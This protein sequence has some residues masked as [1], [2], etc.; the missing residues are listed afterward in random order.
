MFPLYL[1]YHKLSG[2]RLWFESRGEKSIL[3]C[4]RIVSGVW[5]CVVISRNGKGKAFDGSDDG[6]IPSASTMAQINITLNSTATQSAITELT[7]KLGNLKPVMASIGEYML[8]EVRGRFDSETAP[9]GTKWASLAAATIADKARRQKSGTTRSGGSRARVNASPNAILKSTFL[10]RDTIAYKPSAFE[11]RIG[12]PQK[13]G[14]HH[15]YG[16]SRMAARPFLGYNQA[17]IKE[18]EAIVVDALEIL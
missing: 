6:S 8:R 18:I 5:E 15:Q 4:D 1:H 12:T 10:L 7:A 14:V 13:Y 17:D 11:V 9:D 16:T 3:G 2:Y